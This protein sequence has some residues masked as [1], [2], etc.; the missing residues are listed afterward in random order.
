MCEIEDKFK[1][2]AP[3]S[4]KEKPVWYLVTLCTL[5]HLFCI[6]N[7]R[8]EYAQ[9]AEDHNAL[10]LGQGFPDYPPPTGIGEILAEVAL[11]NNSLIHQYTRD[12]VSQSSNATFL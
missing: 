4:S 8:E 12:Y 1:L 10:D 5:T 9:L 3:F 6:G 11:S 2:P 7:F